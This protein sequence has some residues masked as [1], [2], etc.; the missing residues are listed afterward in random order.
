MQRIVYEKYKGTL[1][2]KEIRPSLSL[3][4]ILNIFFTNTA[5]ARIP[6]ALANS[7]FDKEVR[8]TVMTS[9]LSLSS[10]RRRLSPGRRPKV[11]AYA[12]L[13]NCLKGEVFIEFG[14][15]GN[16]EQESLKGDAGRETLPARVSSDVA[17]S[18]P[19]SPA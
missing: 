10:D 16:V 6:S 8:I 19:L 4:T 13:K 12:S 3:S 18:F 1:T 5:S 14:E 7:L 15:A 17:P 9:P 2:W 11:R